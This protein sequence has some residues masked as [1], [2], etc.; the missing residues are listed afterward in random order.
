MIIHFIGNQKGRHILKV[1]EH[2]QA[3]AGITLPT[4]TAYAVISNLYII[5]DDSASFNKCRSEL[6][7]FLSITLKGDIIY[8]FTHFDSL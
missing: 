4:H 8:E 6:F 3:Y 2:F 1:L 5:I 7:V